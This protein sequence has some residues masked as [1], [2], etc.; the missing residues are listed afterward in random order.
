MP[1]QNLHS[2]P[3]FQLRATL[4]AL[5]LA[6]GIGPIAAAGNEASPP[7]RADLSGTPAGEAR[8][9]VKFRS[10]RQV[11]A[12]SAATRTS[13]ADATPRRALALGQR[14]G[15]RLSDG[16]AVSADTQVIHAQGLSN[17]RL[18]QALA[19]DPQVEYVVEDRRRRAHAAVVNDPLFTGGPGISPAAGQ[20]YLQAPN[21]AVVSS[22]NAESAWALTTGRADIV[23]A[24]LDSGVRFNHP[25]L[26]G[27]LLPGYDFISES[28]T[29][30]D[31][32]GRDSN[33]TDPG[34][35]ITADEDANS[36]TLAGCGTQDSAWH[37]TQVAGLVGAA[38]NNGTGMA[39]MGRHV[40]VL[41]VRVLGKCGGYDADIVAGMRWAGGLHV[42]GVPDNPT[43]ARVINMSL[44]EIGSCTVGADPTR[45]GVAKLYLDAINELRQ[46]G[47]VI[48]AS[49]GNDNRA[50]NMP[51]NCAGVIAVSGLR[52]AG[53]KS[54]FSSLGAEV[55]IAAPAGNC[56]NA[57]GECL[58]PI[59]SATNTGKTGPA[60]PSYT[61]GSGTAGLGTSFSAPLVS[62]TVALMLSAQPTLTPTRVLELLRSTVRAF[63]VRPAGATAPACSVDTSVSQIECHCTTAT[64]GAGMLDA[65]AAVRAAA[66]TS[67]L[68]RLGDA[69][70]RIP[71]NGTVTLDASGSSTGA[72]RTVT[73]YQWRIT[74][75]AAVAG[76]TGASTNSTA[77]LSALGS[78]LATVELTVTD[79]S[80]S[81]SRSTAVLR[82]GDAPAA[83]CGLDASDASPSEGGGAMGFGWLAGLA[84]VVALLA[85]GRR[86][87]GSAVQ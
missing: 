1:R 58:Y 51:G 9:I 80:G 85:W 56:V 4:T 57:T 24:V 54:G 28:V 42:D 41:P 21:A 43:P 17:A 82:A 87:A 8:V 37:G 63:P 59:L 53:D 86:R 46:V 26:D 81:T 18:M 30:N 38:T 60:C 47:V 79:S 71:L 33:P 44:G 52:H 20:W 16:A 84:A 77:V 48:V 55:A 2:S 3:L 72:G 76:F 70:T 11:S 40:R 50:V 78:G 6:C 73:G 12:L 23:V 31:G 29:S 64:C 61:T 13:T 66:G 5:V 62:G 22:V 75:G 36:K 68:A 39:G 34:D 65:G 15:L 19:A 67:V 74:D 49:A 7:A 45:P 25:D 35:W 32:D 69:S 14:V 83:V 27:K 10:A